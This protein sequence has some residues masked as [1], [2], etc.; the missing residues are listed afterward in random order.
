MKWVK[1]MYNKK[2]NVLKIKRVGTLKN[3]MYV[4]LYVA[5]CSFRCCPNIGSVY[6]DNPMSW[7]QGYISVRT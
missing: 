4:F 7:R 2:R 5:H 3:F 1:T 6:P